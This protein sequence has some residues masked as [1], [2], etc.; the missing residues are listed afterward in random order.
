MKV[1]DKITLKGGYIPQKL[2]GEALQTY[3]KE[4]SRG[5]GVHR[6]KKDYRRNQ[7]HKGRGWD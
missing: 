1:L 6:S 2:E 5:A 3:L 4:R 7:K